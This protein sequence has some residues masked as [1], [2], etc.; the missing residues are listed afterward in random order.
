MLL[1][2]LVHSRVCDK[3]LDAEA[4]LQSDITNLALSKIPGWVFMQNFILV[5]KI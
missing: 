4:F 2:K 5:L 1:G 3:A